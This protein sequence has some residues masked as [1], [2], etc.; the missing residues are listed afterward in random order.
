MAEENGGQVSKRDAGLC[1]E[2]TP[3]PPSPP[4]W[5][6]ILSLF[7]RSVVSNSLRPH[8][9]QHARVPFLHYLPE[10]AQTPICWV[11][12]AIQPSHPLPPSSP[13]A[14]NLSQYQGLFHWVS[15]PHP[16]AKVLELSFR[17]S[18]SN[19]YS[20]LISFRIDCLISLQSKGLSRVFPTPQVEETTL[21]HSALFMVQLSY[22]YMT[23]GKTIA[24]TISSRDRP[25]NKCDMKPSV[26]H[27]LI[28][29]PSPHSHCALSAG[30]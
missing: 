28:P 6:M 26:H 12:D 21:W 25:T 9:L 5:I 11:S 17:I 27:Y 13:P 18:P 24:L 1:W 2:N 7:S 16:V 3:I 30:I 19:E 20:G 14:L 23:T 22:A 15:S 29:T 10:F 4:H 8:G